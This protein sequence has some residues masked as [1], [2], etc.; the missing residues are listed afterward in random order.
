MY[1]RAGGKMSKQVGQKNEKSIRE[2]ARLL[3]R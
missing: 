2:A 3:D 1:Q